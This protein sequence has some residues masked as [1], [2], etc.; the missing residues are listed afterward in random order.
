MPKAHIYIA[1]LETAQGQ[2]L[3]VDKENISLLNFR[4]SS[5]T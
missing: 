5:G 3:M 2:A 4:I 1:R